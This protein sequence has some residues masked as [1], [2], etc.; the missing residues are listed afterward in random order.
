MTFRPLT[1]KRGQN[2]YFYMLITSASEGERLLLFADH[3]GIR[4]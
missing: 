1:Q 2:G 3:I 4:G